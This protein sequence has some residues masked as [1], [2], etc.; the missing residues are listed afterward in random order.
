MGGRKKEKEDDEDNGKEKCASSHEGKKKPN[1][2]RIIESLL[3][4]IYI[5]TKRRKKK[6]TK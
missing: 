2:L 4:R 6:G 5:P 3:W 1:I